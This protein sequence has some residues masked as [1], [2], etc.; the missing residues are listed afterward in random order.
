MNLQHQNGISSTVVYKDKCFRTTVGGRD[1]VAETLDGLVGIVSLFHPVVTPPPAQSRDTRSESER[2]KDSLINSPYLI[3]KQAALK[4]LHELSV[5]DDR[6]ALDIM[7]QFCKKPKLS[8][9]AQALAKRFKKDFVFITN[10][11]LTEH[12]T[13]LVTR[14]KLMKELTERITFR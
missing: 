13:N 10:Q 3:D 4:R 9:Q 8:P 1:F 7:A 2:L 5:Y 6:T 14:G 12:V 11:E